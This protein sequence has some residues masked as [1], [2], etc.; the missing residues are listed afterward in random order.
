MIGAGIFIVFLLADVFDVMEVPTLAIVMA[1]T[2]LFCL[3]EFVGPS[4]NDLM[5]TKKRG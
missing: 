1:G 3:G 2:A 5:R 4:W